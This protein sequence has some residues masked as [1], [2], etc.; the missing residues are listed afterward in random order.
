MLSI[1][2]FV[3]IA[4]PAQ[5]QEQVSQRLSQAA[6][7]NISVAV[8]GYDVVTYFTASSPLKGIE[9]YQAVYGDKRYLFVSAENQE[10]F[11]V[12]PEKYLPE[13]EEYCGCA[14][15]EGKL[16]E[17]DPKVYK[18]VE[19]KLVLFEDTKAL[20]LWNT[21]EKER[22]KKAQEFW[23]YENKYDSGKRLRDNTRVRLFTF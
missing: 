21:D 12:D 19:G 14:A 22:Y 20:N 6:I 18:I 23:K 16:V 1:G 10:K 13:F 8:D 7:E 2:L 11:S 15:S 5:A 9:T 3:F 4:A 17:A